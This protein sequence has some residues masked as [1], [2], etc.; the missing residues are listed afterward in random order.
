VP[1]VT[2]Y[3]TVNLEVLFQLYV[4]SHFMVCLLLYITFMYGTLIV[5][6]LESNCSPHESTV[7]CTAAQISDSERKLVR[8][9][10]I[11]I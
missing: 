7:P 3:L 9:P 4:Y 5:L 2:I 6:F 10:G 11:S 8:L 1:C